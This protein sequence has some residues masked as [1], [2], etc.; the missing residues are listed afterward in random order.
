MSVSALNRRSLIVI[1]FVT[2]QLLLLAGVL[3]FFYSEQD[4]VK[5]ELEERTLEP[6]QSLCLSL[7]TLLNTTS[8]L[9]GPNE[10]GIELVTPARRYLSFC[11]GQMMWFLLGRPNS[12]SLGRIDYHGHRYLL[13][14]YAAELGKGC[15]DGVVS[16]LYDVGEI[17]DFSYRNWNGTALREL[18][19]SPLLPWQKYLDFVVLSS[20]EN[21][22]AGGLPFITDLNNE[23]LIVA[24]PIDVERLSNLGNY[25]R[26]PNV[27]QLP[28]GLTELL[29]GMWGLVLETPVQYKSAYELDLLIERSDGTLMLYA[30]SGMNAPRDALHR[31]EELT[32]KRVSWYIGATGWSSEADMI[33]F[34]E[35]WEALDSEYP[36][37]HW[38]P[39]HNT[40]A[41]VCEYLE[42]YLGERYHSGC[43][44]SRVRCE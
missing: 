16:F 33:N 7:D 28:L 26:T 13:D 5:A 35:A 1:F 15:R 14:D 29:P 17:T 18:Q 21:S 8:M 42:A 31:T 3:L 32:G 37:L 24:P 4:V 20:L 6:V 43:L 44:G 11:P 34:E 10:A 41:V 40:S 25:R 22:N 2:V 9:T 23:M 19:A 36:H 27:W 38:M 12:Q 30:G 39:N